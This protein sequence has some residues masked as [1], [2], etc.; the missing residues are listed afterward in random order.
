MN[1]T[2]TVVFLQ[3]HCAACNRWYW[4]DVDAT[5]DQGTITHNCPSCKQLLLKTTPYR[6]F[7]YVLSNPSMPGIVKIGMTAR[8]VYERAD[9]L[10][11]STGVPLPFV[12]EAIFRSHDP[13]GDEEKIH[14]YF[15]RHRINID[16]EFFRTESLEGLLV[17][18]SEQ[19]Q[20]PPLMTRKGVQEA[21][22]EKRRIELA[23]RE[24]GKW[25][26]K[27]RLTTA[28]Y[29]AE[30]A[31]LGD[32]GW[33][34]EKEKVFS[35]QLALLDQYET[36][37]SRVNQWK[38]LQQSRDLTESEKTYLNS[39]IQEEKRLLSDI[40]DEK[41]SSPAF[42]AFLDLSGRKIKVR[43]PVKKKAV[44]KKAAKKKAANILT[45]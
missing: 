1:D 33:M 21:A 43:R 4:N 15:S 30:I 17:E 20:L 25:L 28:Q 40:Q 45:L 10:Y 39:S 38:S 14:S 34:S 18:V 44:K 6:G 24:E 31:R 8:N 9:E 19:L 37:F 5:E 11:T 23:N 32:I 42:K 13:E 41:S 36:E 26:T 35:K 22:E 16:R 29:K 2:N 27:Y 12:V 7:I 3:M